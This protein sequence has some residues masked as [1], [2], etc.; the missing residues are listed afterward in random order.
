MSRLEDAADLVE[1]RALVERYGVAADSRDRERFGKVFTPDGVLSISGMELKGR[2]VIPS[3]LDYLDAHYPR[4]MHFMGNHD[5][6][7]EGDTARGTVYCLANHLRIQGDSATNTVMAI[8]YVDRFVRT[9]EGWLIDH[10]ELYFD[11]EEERPAFAEPR[12]PLT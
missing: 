11:W 4:S 1:L 5:V 10:R 2:D 3:I 9:D 12:P 8:R 6:E 7:L